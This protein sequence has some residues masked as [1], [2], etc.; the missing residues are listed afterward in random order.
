LYLL[1]VFDMICDAKAM[2]VDLCRGVG[3]F[4]GGVR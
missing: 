4:D 1:T 2:P 3:A